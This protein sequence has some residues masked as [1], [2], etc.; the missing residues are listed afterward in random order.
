MERD[1]STGKRFIHWIAL[2]IL[3]KPE[4]EKYMSQS[5]STARTLRTKLFDFIFEQESGLQ[6]VEGDCM[7][8][9]L[10]LAHVYERLAQVRLRKLGLSKV[11][12][13]ITF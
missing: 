4:S 1:L 7:I 11:P 5:T 8:S 9:Y 13:Y 10:P 6:M 2:S 12:F 3:Q